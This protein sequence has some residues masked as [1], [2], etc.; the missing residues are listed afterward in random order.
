[1]LRKVKLV[2]LSLLMLGI[3]AGQAGPKYKAGAY[4]LSIGGDKVCVGRCSNGPM[5]ISPDPIEACEGETASVNVRIQ[6]GRMST[7]GDRQENAG[8]EIDWGDGNTDALNGC[9]SWN[10]KHS[11]IQAK[12]YYASARFGEQHNNADNPRGGCSYRCQLQQSATVSIFLKSGPQC[13][14]GRLQKDA[15]K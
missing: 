12:T 8:G 2:T 11:Y 14:G 1:M 4:H 3:L 7:F 9:C 10:L 5:I 15:K 13:R 6:G